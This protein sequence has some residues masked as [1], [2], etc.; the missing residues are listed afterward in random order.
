M[1][2]QERA[3]EIQER[4]V[5]TTA[6]AAQI[7]KLSRVTVERKIRRGEMPATKIGREYRLLGRDMLSLFGWEELKD[8]MWKREFKALL[9]E[10]RTEGERKGI[11]EEDILKTIEEVRREERDKAK[12]SS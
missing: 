4:A 1:Q 5:Y 6:E 8:N 3:I 11:T 10:M 12:G 7:L 2:T 9:N